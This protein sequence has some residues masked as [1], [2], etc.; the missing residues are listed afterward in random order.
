MKILYLIDIS[1]FVFRAFY[2]LPALTTV[3]GIP[4]G[5]VYGF[6][7][8]LMKLRRDV[9]RTAKTAGG[10]EQLSVLWMGI[11]DLSKKTFRNDICPTYKANRKQVPDDLASQFST[12]HEACA[13]FGC[14]VKGVS[15]FEADD[16]IASCAKRAETCGI[17]SI[18]VSSDKDFMQLYRPGVRI[19]DP[20]KSIFISEEHICEKFGVT[21]NRVTDV[22]ALAGD[23]TDGVYGV[24]GIGVK[25][26]AA[27]VKQF[28]SLEALLDN[29][30]TIS[31]KRQRDLITTNIDNIRISKQL[32][33]LR[34]DVEVEINEE[35]L[36]FSSKLEREDIDKISDFY[37]KW[38]FSRFAAQK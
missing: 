22:Q 6:C 4:I 36:R 9:V 8:M 23:P 11:V 35:E 14:P 29:A 37:K 13:A 2:A 10:A 19:F 26:A 33:T 17:E 21:A 34:E 5:A 24:P 27:L 16:V 3:D 7:N 18:I 28:G 1:G 25:T 32:V 12:I 15:N 20:I 31:S 30:Y 38:G